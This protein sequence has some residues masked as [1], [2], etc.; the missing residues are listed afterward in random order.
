MKLSDHIK[1]LAVNLRGK[2][3]R[4]PL[5]KTGFMVPIFSLGG[6]SLIKIKNKYNEAI[7]L[8][9]LAYDMGITYFDTALDYYPS[10]I[11]IGDA[12]KSVRKNVIIATKTENRTRDGA[13]KDLEK[14][15]NNL[16][17]DYIDIWQI[18]HIDHL[19]EVKSWG[20]K[21]VDETFGDSFN[22]TTLSIHE[23][24]LEAISNLC[25]TIEEPLDEIDFLAIA[26]QDHGIAPNG[27]SD[28][29]FRINTIKEA[30]KEAPYPW[31]LAFLGNEVP[32][33]YPRMKSIITEAENFLNNTPSLVMDTSAAA[34]LGA[35]QDENAKKNPNVLSLL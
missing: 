9:Q 6:E 27:M 20:I 14:S 24:C 4:R 15:L 1:R 32:S 18:H 35:L 28:R 22:G 30:L 13:W 7:E 23:V 17:T 8:I 11:R 34:I 3:P 12:L 5:G 29:Q 26:V 19:D 21:I 2:I 16:K 31:G 25:E 10:E 33:Y